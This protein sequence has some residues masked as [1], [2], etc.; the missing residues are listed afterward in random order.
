MMLFLH[1]SIFR[2]F[3]I[4]VL[5]GCGM[6]GILVFGIIAQFPGNAQLPADCGIVFGAAV[7]PASAEAGDPSSL[8]G[9]GILRRVQTAVR[10]YHAHL[11]HR[12]FFTGG[13]GEGMPQSEAAVMARLA[14]D[15]GVKS[16]DI[17]TEDVS[18]STKENLLNTK[19]LIQGCARTVAI[20]D[21]YHL[22]RIRWLAMLQGW[23]DLQTYPA[24]QHAN[25]PFEARSVIREVG[26]FLYSIVD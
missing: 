14:L 9:P 16:Q 18:R 11:V 1:R 26:G 17:Q 12:L 10:L 8:A 5:G 24:D 19:P 25:F 13:R 15:N 21:R 22:A 4:L 3:L 2:F 20:S 7:H 6:I 23:R